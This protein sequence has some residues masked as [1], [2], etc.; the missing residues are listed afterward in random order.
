MWIGKFAVVTTEQASCKRSNNHVSS[1]ATVRELIATFQIQPTLSR[2]AEG[3]PGNFSTLAFECA[4]C[5]RSLLFSH[6]ICTL[7]RLTSANA[8][9]CSTRL[10]IGRDVNSSRHKTTLAKEFQ[11][12][13][14]LRSLFRP[15]CWQS[16]RRAPLAALEMGPR[17]IFSRFA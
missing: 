16:K 15:I 14:S 17:S 1:S 13:F 12:S 6:S 8:V 4:K 11:L 7:V 5:S 10:T 3:E 2:A 9:M